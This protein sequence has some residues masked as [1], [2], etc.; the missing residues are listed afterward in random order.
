MA[1]RQ[2]QHSRL[3]VV[4][5]RGMWNA[6]TAPQR[7]S[8]DRYWQDVLN[9]LPTK[10]GNLAKR[11]GTYTLGTYAD[12]DSVIK[13]QGEYVKADGTVEEW[14]YTD[15]GTNQRIVKYVEGAT[16]P[17]DF[18]DTVTLGSGAGDGMPQFLNFD[19]EL[20]FC[21]GV[22]TPKRYDGSSWTDI[23]SWA[24][25][26]GSTFSQVDTN[27]ITITNPQHV[28]DGGL[29]AGNKIRVTFATAGQVEATIDSVSGTSPMTVNVLGTPFPN[30][31]ETIN[32]VYVEVP[33]PP[34]RYMAVAYDRLWALGP[35]TYAPKRYID[36]TDRMYVYYSDVLLSTTGW[37]DDTTGEIGFLNTSSKASKP[38]SLMAIAEYSGYMIFLGQNETQVWA[39]D[40]PSDTAAFAWQKNVPIGMVHPKLMQ[41]FPNDLVFATRYGLRQLSLIFQTEQLESSAD[42]GQAIDPAVDEQITA[43]LDGSTADYR[44]ARSFFYPKGGFYGFKYSDVTHVF[45]VQ[46]E[47]RGFSR[48][49]QDFSDMTSA[50]SSVTDRLFVAVNNKLKV[51]ADGNSFVDEK[52]SEDGENLYFQGW[53]P[54]LQVSG[55]RFNGRYV[56]LMTS[57][58]TAAMDITLD[59]FVN[60]DVSVAASKTITTSDPVSQW[61]VSDWDVSA[62]DG[63]PRIPYVTD[64]YVAYSVSYRISNNST[65][66]PFELVALELFGGLER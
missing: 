36:E 44:A 43:L 15:D 9:M 14:L 7:L 20:L 10:A 49:N 39:G 59:R 28:S 26:V 29:V 2:G 13:E 52:Y 6:S 21:N 58:E 48:W 11:Y 45:V 47:Q 31:N 55:K 41:K 4:A 40:D 8:A 24:K 33:L 3:Q 32:S 18:V 53:I 16:P 12:T 35:G 65:E 51:Y 56:Q 64:R 60:N 37:H 22:N 19:G 50:F 63:S 1:F 42:I 57:A 54:W 25:E 66:G 46:E 5:P 17:A 27:T 62:W 38:D 61:D 30:P 23:K 34:F